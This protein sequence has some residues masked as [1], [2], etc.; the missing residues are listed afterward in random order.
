MMLSARSFK[1]SL[2]F[3]VLFLDVFVVCLL[4]LVAASR[5]SV[6]SIALEAGSYK[7]EDRRISMSN[8]LKW[9]ASI[10]ASITWDYP[11][12]SIH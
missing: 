5:G 3:G 1:A 10:K 12:Y 11:C 7:R 2:L 6:V 4:C 9:K 8:F